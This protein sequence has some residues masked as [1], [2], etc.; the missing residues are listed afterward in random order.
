MD[1]LDEENPNY[2]ELLYSQTDDEGED[3][4]AAEAE[5]AKKAEEKKKAET[6]T[7]WACNV[8]TVLNP[9]AEGSC[10]VCGSASKPPME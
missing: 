6:P 2:I 10:T 3:A 5:K 7:E 8:C 4:E 9:L 1:P